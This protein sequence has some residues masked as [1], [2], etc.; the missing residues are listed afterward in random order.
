[1]KDTNRTLKREAV[2]YYERGL[3]Q[4]GTSIRFAKNYSAAP[5]V[6]SHGT[7]GA[8]WEQLRALAFCFSLDVGQVFQDLAQMWSDEDM[9]DCFEQLVKDTGVNPEIQINFFNGNE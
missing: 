1:M 2:H 8:I 9:S 3:I 5:G 6:L 7:K 4:I